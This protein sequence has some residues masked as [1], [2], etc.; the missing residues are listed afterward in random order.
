MYLPN[1]H[2]FNDCTHSN[3]SLRRKVKKVSEYIYIC[4][5]MESLSWLWNK[6]NGCVPGD[7]FNGTLCQC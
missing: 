1:P 3:T 2:S 6:Q 7:V 5:F 4:K